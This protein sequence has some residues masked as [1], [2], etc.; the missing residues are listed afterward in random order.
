MLSNR[1]F[2]AIDLP[3]NIK[4]TLIT[5]QNI[6]KHETNIEARLVK[7]EQIHLTLAFLGDCTQQQI[8]A[9]QAALKTIQ[10]KPFTVCLNKCG[11]FPDTNR[12]R[13]F[14]VNLVNGL[15]CIVFKAA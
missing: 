11:V 2:I 15:C 10:H 1:I 14:W 4:K 3:V 6:L 5:L 7:P 12:P 13:V 8:D 9:V